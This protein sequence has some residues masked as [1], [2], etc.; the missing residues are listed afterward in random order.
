M[1]KFQFKDYDQFLHA[2]DE[3]KGDNINEAIQTLAGFLLGV[4]P[5]SR[6]FDLKSYESSKVVKGEFWPTLDKPETLG[7]ELLNQSAAM[8]YLDK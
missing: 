7:Q 4:L 3:L 8:I 5:G 2:A 6:A 1:E